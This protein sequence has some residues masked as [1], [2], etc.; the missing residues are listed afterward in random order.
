M[1]TRTLHERNPDRTAK[2]SAPW[3]FASAISAD[4]SVPLDSRRL[5]GRRD[6]STHPHRSR[7]HHLALPAWFATSWTRTHR[8]NP[9]TQHLRVADFSCSA[10]EP[11]GPRAGRWR[12]DR[13]HADARRARPQRAAPADAA[14]AAYIA[15]GTLIPSQPS[16]RVI[17]RRATA[18]VANSSVLRAG[19][20]SV[21]TRCR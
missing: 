19:S 15:L 13:H 18:A 4:S 16:T 3:R 2:P 10:A 21:S 20:L 9:Y 14:I 5:A 6:A 17:S 1:S 11:R 12:M 8:W 7:P